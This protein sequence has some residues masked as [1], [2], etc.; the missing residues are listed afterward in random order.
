M[1]RK[2]ASL[3]GGFEK[4]VYLSATVLLAAR[5][6]PSVLLG[7]VPESEI[8]ASWTRAIHILRDFQHDNTSAKHCVT[9][10]GLL[11]DKLSATKETVPREPVA[12][13][14][15]TT[16]PPEILPSHAQNRTEGDTLYDTSRAAVSDMAQA[17]EWFDSFTDFDFADMSWLNAVP[18][19][20]FSSSE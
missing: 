20:L 3:I 16:L 8:E 18:G 6:N 10:L 9:V 13:G 1:K 12:G 17:Y 19:D 15:V 5:L 7:E 11:Y 14:D 2:R 4:D